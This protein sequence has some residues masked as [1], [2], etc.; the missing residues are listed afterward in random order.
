MFFQDL[1][2]CKVLKM[3]QGKIKHSDGLKL[4]DGELMKEIGTAGY[5]YL[6]ILQDDTEK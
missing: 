6:G 3:L 2:K 1:D 5:K 4:P